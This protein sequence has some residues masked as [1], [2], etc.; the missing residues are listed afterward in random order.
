MLSCQR[1]SRANVPETCQL[2]IFTCQCAIWCAYFSVWHANV[3]K[4]VPI[5]RKFLLQNAKGNWYSLLLYKKFWIILD[6]IVIHII[7]ICTLQKNCIKF[8]FYTS[9]QIKEQCEDFFIIIFFSFLFLSQKWKC[10]KTC[11]LYATSNKDFLEFSTVKTT[12]QNK[13]I[14]VNIVIFL[15]WRSEIVIRKYFDCVSFRFLR[16]YFWVQ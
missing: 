2:L 8:H 10:K 5:F 16:L 6:I 12:K 3:P 13:K 7:C 9:C 11:F 15:S 14:Y 4:G 1:G